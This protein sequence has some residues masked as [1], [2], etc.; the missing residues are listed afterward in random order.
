MD[1]VETASGPAENGAAGE[2]APGEA[3]PAPLEGGGDAAL[4]RAQASLFRF[5]YLVCGDRALAEDLTIDALVRVLPRW[6]RGGIADLD[7]YLRR[8][9][10][11]LFTSWRRRRA[12]ERADLARRAGSMAPGSADGHLGRIDDQST[13]WPLLLRLPVRQRAVLV[14]RFVEDR[15]VE[16]VAAVMG[17][18]EGTVKSQTSKALAQLRRWIDD[19]D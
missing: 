8:V 6:R 14:L 9:V 17:T 13:L 10:V 15:S 16:H 11:N 18:T 2:T 19:G 3:T 5:A 12:V 4:A 7:A 1:P